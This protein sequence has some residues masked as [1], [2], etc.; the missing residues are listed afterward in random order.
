MSVNIRFPS[1]TGKTE[2]E[3]IGQIRSYLI[4]LVQQLNWILSTNEPATGSEGKG[5]SG[6][7]VDAAAIA[8]LK[9]QLYRATSALDSYY[10][11]INTKLEGYVKKEELEA[12]KTELTQ[13]LSEPDDQYVSKSDFE[14]YKQTNDQVIAGLQGE[15]ASLRQMINDMQNTGGD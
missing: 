14:T 5:A 8:E 4:Q 11:N 6:A 7:N 13:T 10:E 3:Q 15:I 1:I 12:Y 9:A 2:A